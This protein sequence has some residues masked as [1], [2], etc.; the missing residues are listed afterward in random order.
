MGRLP[1]RQVFV[2]A[3]MRPPGHPH[4]SCAARGAQPLL[5]AMQAELAKRGCWESVGVTYCGCV[6]QCD[7]GPATLVYPDGVVLRGLTPAQVPALFDRLL[8]AETV[9]M[10]AVP[11]DAA[12]A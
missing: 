3:Q 7:G 4:G 2:C 8:N 9:S 1:L 6:G 12:S 11:A 10:P 5:Q